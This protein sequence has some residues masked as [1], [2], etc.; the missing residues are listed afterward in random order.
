MG[1]DGNAVFGHLDQRFG[2]RNLFQQYDNVHFPFSLR[3]ILARPRHHGRTGEQLRR[4]PLFARSPGMSD[5][6][7]SD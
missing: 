7:P 1:L 5:S 2:G 6:P 3:Q 4:Q